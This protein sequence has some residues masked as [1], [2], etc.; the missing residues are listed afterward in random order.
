MDAVIAQEESDKKRLRK[1]VEEIM[2]ENT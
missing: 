2:K 1:A